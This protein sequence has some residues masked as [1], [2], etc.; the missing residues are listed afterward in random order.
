MDDPTV[1]DS[2]AVADTHIVAGIQRA[3]RGL[4]WMAI[5]NRSPQW[6]SA[7]GTLSKDEHYHL[8]PPN[9]KSKLPALGETPK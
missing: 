3:M 1:T 4:C 9:Q 8:A 6:Q 2:C 5:S 7:R